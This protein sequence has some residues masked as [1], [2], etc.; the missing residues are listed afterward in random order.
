MND[1]GNLEKEKVKDGILGKKLKS[2]IEED[3]L[4]EE[5]EEDDD[6]DEEE[7]IRQLENKLEKE[8]GKINFLEDAEV[9]DQEENGTD[10]KKIGKTHAE[11][12]IEDNREIVDYKNDML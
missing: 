11:M 9:E 10:S 4:E 3:F 2:R 5:A 12:E 7:Y 6:E 1:E 8:K